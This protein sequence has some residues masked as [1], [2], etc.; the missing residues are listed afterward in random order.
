MIYNTEGTAENLKSVLPLWQSS[1]LLKFMCYTKI[2]QQIFFLSYLAA[3][4]DKAC[5]QNDACLLST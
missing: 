2:R 5:L 4:R 1:I 3:P